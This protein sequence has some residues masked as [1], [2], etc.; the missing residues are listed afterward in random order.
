MKKIAA[1]EDLS[2][3]GGRIITSN[4]NETLLIGSLSSFGEGIFGEGV[5][6]AGIVAVEGAMHSCPIEGH[7][8]TTIAAVTTK[9]FHN[10]KLILTT[11]AVA[12]CGAKIIPPDRKVNVE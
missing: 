5:F 11:D 1:Q 8:V 3:H 10:S 2:D 4:Q 6:G 9:S 12:G 7:G